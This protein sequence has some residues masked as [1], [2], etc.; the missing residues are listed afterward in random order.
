M[1]EIHA[2]DARAGAAPAART[3]KTE[4][5]P[6][7]HSPLIDF[8][9]LGGGSMPVMIATVLLF[10]KQHEAAILVTVSMLAVFINNP[11]FMASYQIFYE[12]FAEKLSDRSS[13]LRLRYWFAG[14][15]VPAAM[16]L[17]FAT[18][19]V[20]VE[21][22]M[23]GRAVNVMFFLVGW[24]YVK[25]GYGI[26]MVESVLHRNFFSENEK[27]VLR[28]NGLAAW[29]FSW[30]YANRLI[31]T[32]EF[33]GFEHVTLGIPVE[34]AWIAGAAAVATGAATLAVLSRRAAAGRLPLN[35]TCGYLAA[36]YFWMALAYYNPMFLLLGP[37]FHSLQYL[38]VV[39]RYQLNKSE[40]ERGDGQV[41]LLSGLVEV[42]AAQAGLIRFVFVGMIAGALAFIVVP[43]L[44]DWAIAYKEE[45]FGPSMFLA[46]FIVFINIHHYFL[47]NVM[48]RKEN[49]DIRANL[50]R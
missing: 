13:G 38:A 48:W 22:A 32:S 6:Y 7:L 27:T 3:E 47:D 24:H 2:G 30:L 40:T 50:F 37:A 34:A 1:T 28:W 4:R 14:I 41:S 49:P 26:L 35:G 25:Q 19:I 23:I 45:L 21:P 39:W 17:Y 29:I 44:L 12:R 16:V 33:K 8:L 5:T 31:D 36:V 20:A 9:C 15:V 42:T 43:V 46:I 10:G 11:H 18:S